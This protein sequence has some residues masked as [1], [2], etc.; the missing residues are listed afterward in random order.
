MGTIYLVRHGQ[1]SLGADDYDALSDTGM[2]QARLLGGWFARSGRRFDLVA[3][4][5]LRRHRETAELCLS[6]LAPANGPVRRL[7]PDR[8][9]DESD[10]QEILARLRPDL[11]TPQA[12]RAWLEKSDDTPHRTFQRIFAVACQ[13]WVGGEHEHEYSDSWTALRGRA[14]ASI[15]SVAQQCGSGQ[16]ALV[17]TSAGPIAAVCQHLLAIPDARLLDL[18]FSI[19]NSSVTKLLCQSG[20]PVRLGLSYFN[21]I[22]HLEPMDHAQS[23]TYR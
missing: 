13:R 22:A 15:E 17:F 21:A 7:E 9:L 23:I 11:A 14:V 1:A 2:R 3:G 12:L 5:R 10:H 6:G 4:G 19:Y 20:Q 16:S 18:L 8:G